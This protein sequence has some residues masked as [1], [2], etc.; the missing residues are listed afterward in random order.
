MS[1]PVGH[2]FLQRAES[3]QEEPQNIM[4]W[5]SERGG[6]VGLPTGLEVGVFVGPTIVGEFVGRKLIVGEFVGRV[7]GQQYITVGKHPAVTGG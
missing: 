3:V 4:D 6:C 5:I 1:S 2:R 7:K